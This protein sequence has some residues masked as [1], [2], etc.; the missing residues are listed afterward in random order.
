MKVGISELFTG[1]GKR[2]MQFLRDASMLIEEVGFDAIWFPEHVVMFPAYTSQYPYG[3]MGQT[4]VERLRGVYDPFVG[5]AAIAMVTKHVRLGTYV[6]VI[7]QR[8]PIVMARDA[9]TVDGLSGGRFDFGVGVG[10]SAEEYAALGVPFERRGERTDEYLAAMKVLWSDDEVTSFSGEFISFDPLMAFPKPV[11]R[12]HPPIVVGGNSAATIRRIVAHGDG[13]AGYNLELAEVEAFIERLDKALTGAGR[14]LSEIQLRV[15]RRAKGKT[16][17]D[18]EDDARYLEGA[19][20][21]GLHEVVVSPRMPDDG[22]E[23]MTRRYAEIVGLIP[24]TKRTPS[25]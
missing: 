8:N 5:L 3:T 17:K 14:S 7:A 13:W 2:T 12:P 24:H 9:A 16:E 10:W 19:A 20:K 15:G 6:C 18:W 21:L 23:A 22:Y 4:E 11:Q 25:A 1:E